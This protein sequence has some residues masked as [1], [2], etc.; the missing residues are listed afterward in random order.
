M[1][2]RYMPGRLTDLVASGLPGEVSIIE[3]AARLQ[4]IRQDVEHA[5]ALGEVTSDIL[6]Q[7]RGLNAV[8]VAERLKIALPDAEN[9]SNRGVDWFLKEGVWVSVLLRDDSLKYVGFLFQDDRKDKKLNR[10]REVE[11]IVPMDGIGI[12]ADPFNDDFGTVFAIGT[13]TGRSGRL[14]ATDRRYP[15]F[16]YDRARADRL[17][18]YMLEGMDKT[19]PQG[20]VPTQIAS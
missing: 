3:R 17:A 10:S 14:I 1:V 13:K 16:I 7:E 5:Y 2:D 12:N 4:C 8:E 19:L 6:R 11:M 15:I 18:S 9:H 20:L